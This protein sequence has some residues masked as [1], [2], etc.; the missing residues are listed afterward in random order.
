MR[1]TPKL[2]F[3]EFSGDWDEKRLG[4]L[5]NL[6]S[7]KRIFAS[8]YVSE[9]IPFYRGKEITE[10]KQ[11]KQPTDILYITNEKYDEIKSSFGVPKKNELLLTAVGTLGNSYVI[12]DNTP[13]YF[14]DG[15]LIWFQDIKVNANYLD[16]IISSEKGKK[17]ILDSAIGSTQ[18]ALTI[19][20]LNKLKY[21][22]PN[23]EE[24][25][26]IASFFSLIDDKISLQSEKVEAL[27]DYKNGMMQ[28]IFSRELRFKDDEGRDYPKWEEKKL[29]ELGD[30]YTGLS[31][32]TKENFGVGEAKYV[33]YK[34]VFGNTIAKE[35]EVDLVEINEGENQNKV[36]KGDLL[37]TTSSETPE[38]VGMISC[39][40][41]DIEDLYLNS[42]CFGYRLFDLEQ[43]SP[44]FIAYL[45]RSK[46]Y[47]RKISILGQGSTRYNISKTELMKMKVSVPNIEE[48]RKI[49]G[50]LLGIESKIEKEQEKLYFLNEYKKGLLQQMFV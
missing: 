22:F 6:T 5:A 1:K 45:L 10:L 12:R 2:R 4:D 40:N 19:V 11:G 43:Y 44:I 23:I 24:Q 30:T 15:N 18:K 8:D 47:R 9:G 7:S 46:G 42:F 48:Q 27:K 32:K 16:L 50:L 35:E 13:F 36:V 21:K 38:E 49:V 29:N 26:K 34:N 14:K 37:F 25:E 39:W 20:E 41:Y 31:G 3:K 17:K 33:I 28:K